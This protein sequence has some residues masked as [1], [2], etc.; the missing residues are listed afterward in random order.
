MKLQGIFLPVAIPFDHNGALYAVKVQHNVEKWNRTALA[1]FV[2]SGPENAYLT[3]EERTRMWEWVAEYSAPEKLLIAEV[4][5]PGVRQT[6]EAANLAETLGYV[7]AMVRVP[8]ETHD[9]KM[10]YFRAVADQSKIPVI[11]DGDL[12]PE[13]IAALA[14]H[15]NIVAICR[16]SL[17]HVEGMPT[18][19]ASALTLSESFAAGAAGAVQPFAN[20]APYALISIWEAHRTREFEAARD[21]QTRIT[22]IVRLVGGTWGVAALKHAMDLNGYY[23]GPPRLPLTV[24]TPDQQKE[25]EQAL[26]GIKG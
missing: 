17:D 4:G 12:P 15:P 21:W 1:G 11:I 19:A 22:A 10:I 20:A 16:G 7:A 25:V 26:D 14:Q 23:G 18:L 5:A 2:V 24:L 9:A 13:S 3:F 6:A 8:V